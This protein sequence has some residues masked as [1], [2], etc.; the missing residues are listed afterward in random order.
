[1]RNRLSVR[2]RCA[3][4]WFAAFAFIFT[5]AELT[6]GDTIYT[7]TDPG[8]FLGFWGPDVFIS[9]SVGVRFTP[10]VDYIFDSAGLWFMNNDFEGNTHALVRVTLRTDDASTPSVSI[11][12]NVIIEEMFLTVTTVGWDPVLETVVSTLHPRL[13]AGQNYWIVAESNVQAGVN[14]VWVMAGESTGFAA[15][16]DQSQTNWQP[17]GMGAVPATR[18]FGTAVVVGDVDG[19]GETNGLDVSRFVH[20]ALGAPVS[21]G[22]V[23]RADI[24]CD[25]A[26]NQFDVT[27]FLDALLN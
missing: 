19:N 22:D 20:A 2:A 16:T 26:V 25:E 23:G 3:L 7:T 4:G 13:C 17:G 15:N 1:M 10:A 21:P 8:G 18:V 6:R 24:N 5:A 14:G 11:P 9:Q 27:A 12:S